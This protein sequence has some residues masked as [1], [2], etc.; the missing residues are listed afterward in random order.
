MTQ[1]TFES[2]NPVNAPIATETQEKLAANHA[3]EFTVDVDRVER[4]IH[5]MRAEQNLPMG[6]LAGL[7]A[8]ILG[9]IIWALITAI[10]NYQIGWM[11][12]GIGFLSGISVRFFG[13][14]ID[15]IYGFIGAG[16]ALFGCM[17]G[18]YLTS[19]Y[20]ISGMEGI[21]VM[22]LI[23]MINLDGIIEI[24]TATFQGMDLLFYGLAIYA[25]YQFAFRQI[26]DE[27]LQHMVESA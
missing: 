7:A 13:K 27:K 1:E 15:Q 25:G 11:A 21:P 6:F 17:L 10:T 22:Q 14:G 8:A 5:G 12:I 18:N 2:R 4:V 16:L 24:M 20:F 9:A 23:L 19:L 3:M 26:D